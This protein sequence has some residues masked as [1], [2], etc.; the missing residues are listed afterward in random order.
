MRRRIIGLIS[1][2]LLAAGGVFL[3]GADGCG[4]ANPLSIDEN[5]EIRIGQQAAAETEAQYGLA[6]NPTQTTRV[7]RIG[8]AIAAVSER[9]N[10]PWTFKIINVADVNA[11]AFPGGPIYVTRGLIEQNLPDAEL[12]G[13][14]GHEIAHV[15]ERHSVNAIERAMTYSLLSDLV[16]GKNAALRTATDLA[17]QYAIQLP[18]SRQ[19]EYEADA[20]GIR[21]AYNAGYPAN[22]MVAFL[23]RL[24]QLSGPS[25]SPEWLSTHPLTTERVQRAEQITAQ[26]SGQR[27][28]VP[29]SLTEQE[30]A[31]M[32]KLAEEKAPAPAG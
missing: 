27:R 22:G 28:P 3:L 2:M 8:R 26:V 24:Q 19:D 10:L 23:R 21:L 1:T 14:L 4:S 20:V 17:V 7:Q 25:R 32:K 16:L 31:V 29:I 12:S 11:F 13:V 30:Q 9:P 18:H 5:T 6:N 15:N